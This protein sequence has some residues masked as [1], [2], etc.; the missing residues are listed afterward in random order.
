[1]EAPVRATGEIKP[2]K[3]LKHV[4][5]VYPVIARQ[6]GIEGVVVV[7]ATTDIYGIVQDVKVINSVSLLDQAA[8]E[9]VR[10][11]VYEPMIIDGQPRR[12]IFTVR[13][14]FEHK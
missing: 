14:T 12:V 4:P 2:P 6:R 3:L 8:I 7:E 5:P 13:V 11:W 9:A 1:M 10:Q